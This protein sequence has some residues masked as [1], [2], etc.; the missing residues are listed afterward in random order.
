MSKREQHSPE[1]RAK[2][3]LEALKGKATVADLS[4]RFGIH[5]TMVHIWKKALPEGAHLCFGA[6]AGKPPGSTGSS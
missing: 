4:S 2:V 6:A 3:A 5:P 1:F